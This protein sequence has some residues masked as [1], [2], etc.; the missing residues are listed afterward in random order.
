ML[1]QDVN[2]F[3]TDA[4]DLVSLMDWLK[5]IL[6]RL[7]PIVWGL[8]LVTDILLRRTKA[9]DNVFIELK[10]NESLL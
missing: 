5:K 8:I 3:F 4:D 7:M 9:R 2:G 10:Y 1:Y 6:R